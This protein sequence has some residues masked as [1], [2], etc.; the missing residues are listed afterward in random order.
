[1]ITAKDVASIYEVPLNFA[2][3]GVDTL[4]L[5]YLRIEAPNRDYRD[6]RHCPPQ[7]HPKDT[8]TIAS[9]ASMW[10]MRIPKVAKEA[11]VHG[12]LAHNLNCSSIGS[13]LRA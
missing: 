10:S 7:L 9:W 5:K 2:H 12:A 6:G 8:V 13:K 11:L 1:V 3:E 4:V